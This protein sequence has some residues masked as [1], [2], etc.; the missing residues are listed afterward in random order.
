MLA[1]QAHSS[2]TFLLNESNSE[3]PVVF[4]STTTLLV[5]TAVNNHSSPTS[6]SSSTSNF[7]YPSVSGRCQYVN[8][9]I[10]EKKTSVLA[11]SPVSM[12]PISFFQREIMKMN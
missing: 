6:V 4:S 5:S 3:V 11:Y 12:S 8:D 9:F 1:A 10:I 7:C 2:H